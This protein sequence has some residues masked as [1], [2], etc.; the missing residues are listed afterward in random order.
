MILIPEMAVTSNSGEQAFSSRMST[1]AW[2]PPRGPE[3]P[4][5]LLPAASPPPAAGSPSQTRTRMRR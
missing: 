3:L 5:L 4:R 1:S 2:L